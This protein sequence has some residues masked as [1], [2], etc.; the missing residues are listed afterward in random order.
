MLDFQFMDAGFTKPTAHPSRGEIPAR[1]LSSR[2]IP[3]ALSPSGWAGVLTTS[4][5]VGQINRTF[6]KRLYAVA[7][8]RYSLGGEG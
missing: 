7:E 2:C 1:D 3:F 5:L 8:R 6:W 4:A